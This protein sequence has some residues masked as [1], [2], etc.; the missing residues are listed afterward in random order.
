[1]K[2]PDK[3]KPLWWL[4][5]VSVLTAFLSLRFQDL[6]QGNAS[7]LDSF[8]AVLL[9][10]LLLAPLFSEVSL[11]GITLKQ[12]IS[13]LKS[14]VSSA[15][16][17]IRN[18]MRSIVDVRN[19]ASSHVY[20]LMNPPPDVALPKLEEQARLAVDRI[21]KERGVT[22]STEPA[23]A[24]PETI[25][26][27]TLRFSLENEIKRIASGRQIGTERRAGSALVHDL[28]RAEIVN[29]DLAETVRDLYAIC[30]SAIHGD[31]V[32]SKQVEFAL[33]TGRVVLG[34]LR[35]IE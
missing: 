27:F 32:S 5:V 19:T 22:G 14:D 13:E 34:A 30:S 4:L 2:L 29:A 6:A 8:A 17:E 15:L 16:G 31:P 33:R 3:I 20:N 10:A 7:T 12:Q 25:Q 21:L 18:E 28:R 35:E 24:P 9:V 26:L 1:M 23:S 11:A